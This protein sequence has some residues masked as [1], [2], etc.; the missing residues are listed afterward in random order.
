[1]VRKYLDGEIS[2][3][4]VRVRIRMDFKS[5]VKKKFLGN[6]NLIKAAEDTR[7]QQ[8]ALLR[9]VPFQGIKVE[10]I[11]VAMEIYVVYDES[12]GEDVAYA[13]ILLILE[14]D[15][16]DDVVRFIMRDEFRKVEIIEPQEI[17][18]SKQDAERLLFKINTELRSY[19]NDLDKRYN[20]R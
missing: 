2:E 1:M 14:A 10:D 20:L 5:Q 8:V 7:E 3:T 6:N 18:M 15:S 16:F 4:T 17:F 19:R 12:T 11:D 9:N 13:P